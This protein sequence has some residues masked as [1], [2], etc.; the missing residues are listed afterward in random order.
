[1]TAHG[2]LI[3]RK[4]ELGRLEAHLRRALGGEGAL[5][6]VSGEA[7]VGKTRLTDELCGTTGGPILRGAAHH[8]ATSAYG[9]VVAALRSALRS[10]ADAL[11]DCGPLGDH[12]RILLP[13]LGRAP[14][15]VEAGALREAMRCAFAAVARDSGALIILDDLHWSDAATL[16]FLGEIAPTLGELPVLILGAYRSDELA[17]EHPLRRVRNELRRRRVL[18]EIT[19]GPLAE[20]GTGAL[21]EQALG[22]RPSRLLVR[23]VHDRSQGVPFFVE[24]LASALDSERRLQPG[25]GG[26]ELAEG[27]GV[28]VPETVRDAVLLRCAD[29]SPAGRSAAEVAAVAGE[30]FPLEPVVELADE[31]GVGEL[32]EHGLLVERGAGMA[33]FR[34]A[35]VRDALYRD[36]SWLRRRALHRELGERLEDA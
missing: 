23:A 13:E 29:L 30:R 20:S 11:L 12:L 21:L 22:A 6:L 17:R 2:S 8:D 1:M 19:L 34:H 15:A 5:V 35:L 14:K 33:A 3:E 24:E 16:E 25:T 32:F 31:A 26:L 10:D 27:S 36:V 9:P 18:A 28:S 4:D 7:G